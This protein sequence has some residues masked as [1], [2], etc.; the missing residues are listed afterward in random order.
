MRIQSEYM[1]FNNRWTI[2]SSY[3][4]QVPLQHSQ[5][6]FSQP[7]LLWFEVLPVL[8]PALWGL[9]SALPNLSSALPDLTLALVLATVLERHFGSGSGSEPTRCQIG[10]PGCQHTPTVNSGTVRC[11]SP[12]PSWLGGLSAGRPA[13]PAVDLYNILVSVVGSLYIIKIRY[14][15]AN[16]LFLDVLQSVTLINLEY[17]FCLLSIALLAIE[18]VNSSVMSAPMRTKPWLPNIQDQILLTFCWCSV[19]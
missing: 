15:T 3:D 13:G 10:G 17:A 9:S 8:S 16:N 1:S 4:F 14:S 18:A 2:S 19:S 11:K 12:N 5:R 6:C 7:A